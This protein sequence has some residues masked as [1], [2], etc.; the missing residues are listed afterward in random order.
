MSSMKYESQW[1]NQ[2]TT[3]K[4]KTFGWVNPITTH[5]S[6]CFIW[7]ILADFFFIKK[8]NSITKYLV[9]T[10]NFTLKRMPF[11]LAHSPSSFDIMKK[12]SISIISRIAPCWLALLWKLSSHIY[13]NAK[14]KEQTARPIMYE[15]EIVTWGKKPTAMRVR[16]I[17]GASFSAFLCTYKYCIIDL[18]TA[19]LRLRLLLGFFPFWRMFSCSAQFDRSVHTHGP[20]IQLWC[21]EWQK[22]YSIESSS[23]FESFLGQFIHSKASIG[24]FLS[25][26]RPLRLNESIFSHRYYCSSQRII[27]QLIFFHST[28]IRSLISSIPLEIFCRR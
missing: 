9:W 15:K 17:G 3:T 26:N 8:E 7:I 18:G 24:I 27:S 23:E 28:E 20:N 6:R 1:W 11:S 22:S 14:C 16:W 25:E 10:R 2:E 5:R 21:A 12:I 13:F 4:T 19:L